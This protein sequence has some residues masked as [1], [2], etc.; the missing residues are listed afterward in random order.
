V[1]SLLNVIQGGP[2]YQGLLV[3]LVPLLS[4]RIKQLFGQMGVIFSR[5]EK[6]ILFA[7]A[8]SSALALCYMYSQIF[9]LIW[10]GMS[11]LISSIIRHS[12]Y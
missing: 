10:R 11:I 3:V 9:L 8:D 4:Q 5:F 6:R 1:S 2:T 12:I 7:C